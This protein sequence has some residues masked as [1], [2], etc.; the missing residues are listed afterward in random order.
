MKKLF[1]LLIFFSFPISGQAVSNGWHCTAFMGVNVPD[2]YA[3]CQLGT[4]GTRQ[5]C[6]CPGSCEL[7]GLW[8]C[9]GLSTVPGNVQSAETQLTKASESAT[10]AVTEAAAKKETLEKK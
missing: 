8:N 9:P 6:T 5:V 4:S 2:S 3:I 7:P 1:I 10:L